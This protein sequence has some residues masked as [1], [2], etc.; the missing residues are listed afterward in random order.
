MSYKICDVYTIHNSKKIYSNMRIDK[1]KKIIIQ[2]II[3]NAGMSF[4]LSLTSVA[5]T[6]AG[7]SLD[8]ITIL[9]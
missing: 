1:L 9:N 2:K 5:S 7:A 3:A 6:I 8:L 4:A